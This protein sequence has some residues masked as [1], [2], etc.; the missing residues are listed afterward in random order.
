MTTAKAIRL[1][2]VVTAINVLVAS[3]FSIVGIIHPQYLVPV[4]SVRTQASLILAMYAAARTI[5]LALFVFG[6]IYKRAAHALLILGALAGPCNCWMPGSV[7]LSVILE[8]ALGRSL[9]PS[10][11]SSWCICFTDPCRS[12]RKPRA[13]SLVGEG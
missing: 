11:N 4:E 10:S 9:S 3:G 5:P 12:R 2:S 7:C 8:N 1:A 6:A 13:D